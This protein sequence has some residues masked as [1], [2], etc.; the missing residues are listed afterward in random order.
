MRIHFIIQSDFYTR[1][2]IDKIRDIEHEG[3][4]FI[5]VHAYNDLTWIKSESEKTYSFNEAINLLKQ[6]NYDCVYL[7]FLSTSIAYLILRSNLDK[8][9]LAWNM[10]GADYYRIPEIRDAYFMQESLQFAPKLKP[11]LQSFKQILKLPSYDLVSKVIKK[12]QYYIWY[13]EEFDLVVNTINPNLTYVDFEYY[14]S[15]HDLPKLNKSTTSNKILIGNSDDPTNNHIDVIRYISS[16]LP[17]NHDLIIPLAG[18]SKKYIATIEA[19]LLEH[20]LKAHL[21]LESKSVEEFFEIL[22]SVEYVVFGQLR[23]QGCGTLFPLLYAGKKVF[24]WKENPLYK[25][26]LRW[27]IKLDNLNDLTAKSFIQLTDKNKNLNI[28]ILEDVLSLENNKNR[29]KKA[30]N[31]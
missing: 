7:H 26:M 21:I 31:I 6:A 8:S 29:W 24:M 1:R 28:E 10:W 3:H 11:V 4:E 18:A 27:G 12:C 17:P 30:L 9:K 16:N 22:S 5:V 19:E 25:T 13:K 2:I 23:Q 14:L 20:G 15:I